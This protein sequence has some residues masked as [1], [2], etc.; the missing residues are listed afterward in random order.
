MAVREQRRRPVRPRRPADT[1]EPDLA[2]LPRGPVSD[3]SAA[4]NLLDRIAVLLKR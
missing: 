4:A 1:T 3:T 2:P